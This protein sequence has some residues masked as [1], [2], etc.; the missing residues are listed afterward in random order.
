MADATFR[1]VAGEEG[2]AHEQTVHDAVDVDSGGEHDGEAIAVLP[3]SMRVKGAES[4]TLAA[5]E[6]RRPGARQAERQISCGI[7]HVSQIFR[8]AAGRALRLAFR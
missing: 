1:P 4:G 7:R 2:D 3:P 5:H 6:E 8:A